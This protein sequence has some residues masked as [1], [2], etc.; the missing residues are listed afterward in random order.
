[1]NRCWR[2]ESVPDEWRQGIIVKIP[3][4][5]D[6][7]DCN[8]WRSITLLSVPG[9]V[10]CTYIILLQRI[11]DAVD[12]T[13]RD[14]QAGFRKGR[15]CAEQ[16]FALRNIIEQCVEFQQPLSINFVDFKKAFDSVHR[17]SLWNIARLYG[18][19]QL[20]VNIFRTLYRHSRCCVKTEDGFTEFFDIITGVRQGC[21]LSPFLFLLVIDFIMMKAVSEPDPPCEGAIM[22]GNGRL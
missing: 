15:S 21:I 17:E 4:K 16:I 9:K 13:L 18:I 20:H 8:N 6:I 3:K 5:G 19:L 7:G 22:M 11:R 12:A 14:E 10:F 2:A 1:V